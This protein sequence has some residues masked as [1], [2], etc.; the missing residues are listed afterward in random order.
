MIAVMK[1]E[2]MW[3]KRRNSC[4]KIQRKNINNLRRQKPSYQGEKQKVEG[5]IASIQL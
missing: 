5:L 1:E 4:R 2:Q 3:R